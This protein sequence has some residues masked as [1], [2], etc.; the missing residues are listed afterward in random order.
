MTIEVALDVISPFVASM[1]IRRNVDAYIEALRESGASYISPV[2]G[3]V[4]TGEVLA[5]AC[6]VIAQWEVGNELE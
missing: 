5:M 1:A 6:R 2:Y 3:V 4:V